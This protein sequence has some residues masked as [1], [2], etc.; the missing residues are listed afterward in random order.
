[1]LYQP[2]SVRGCTT[3]SPRSTCACDGWPQTIGEIA[4][5]N[6]FVDV[7]GSQKSY[8]SS[9]QV[10][11]ANHKIPLWTNKIKQE[12]PLSLVCCYF[13]RS[14]LSSCASSVES[15]ASHVFFLTQG[16]SR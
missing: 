1:M 13:T 10:F 8:Y 4:L 5:Q 2:Y 3:R 15:V 7:L 11:S 9:D 12:I 14:Y 6:V 16:I